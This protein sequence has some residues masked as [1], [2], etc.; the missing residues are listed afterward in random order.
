MPDVQ[1]P[2]EPN[3]NPSA[4]RIEDL[5]AGDDAPVPAV[6]EGLPRSFRMR[7]DKHYVEMLDSPPPGDVKSSSTPSP[8]AKETARATSVENAE[9]VA[10]AVRAGSALEQSLAAL[11][12]STTLLANRGGLASTV[13][14][15]LIRAEAWRATCLLQV[16]RFLRGEIAPSLKSVQ[17]SAVLEQVLDA[18]DAE[19]R[20]RGITVERRVNLGDGRIVT[21]EQLIVGALSGFL[22]TMIGGIEATDDGITVTAES[23]GQD[24]TFIFALHNEGIEWVRHVDGFTRVVA[25]IGGTVALRGE[26][27]SRVSVTF[28]GS[29]TSRERPT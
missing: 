29:R 27:P 3:A 12:T 4:I 22:M 6:R 20:L 10:A 13:A 25:G 8:S 15:G 16:S 5:L 9:A 7:A 19:R 18:I 21:D 17:A 1:Y 28:P 2:D 11:R 26:T 14:A 24:V 23:R